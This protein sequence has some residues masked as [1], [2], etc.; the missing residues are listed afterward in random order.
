MRSTGSTIFHLPASFRHHLHLCIH[1]FTFLHVN[2]FL[3]AIIVY[4]AR[5]RRR[6]DIKGGLEVA[7]TKL[8]TTPAL[9]SEPQNQ[10]SILGAPSKDT[11]ASCK[12]LRHLGKLHFG[13]Q[14]SFHSSFDLPS[15]P[16]SAIDRS[17]TKSGLPSS[18]F[19]SK[20]TFTPSPTEQAKQACCDVTGCRGPRSHWSTICSCSAP[21][22]HDKHAAATQAA[23]QISH[24]PPYLARLTAVEG[25]TP[26]GL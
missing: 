22:T 26:L 15:S 3:R 2:N 10:F 23:L 25:E 24:P 18:G 8:D 6:R 12:E 17:H 9:L 20:L 14:I 19:N 7:C 13:Y 16:A 11:P 5:G 4:T 1:H 21:R